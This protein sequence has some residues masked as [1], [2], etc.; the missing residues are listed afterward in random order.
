MSSDVLERVYSQTKLCFEFTLSQLLLR[1]PEAKQ[2]DAAYA[3]PDIQP[4]S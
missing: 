2:T 1:E 3:Q 4:T